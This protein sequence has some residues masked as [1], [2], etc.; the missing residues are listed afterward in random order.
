[1]TATSRLR[2]S[3][4]PRPE[5]GIVH[6]GPGAFFR[7]FCATY[8]AEAMKAEVGN[9]GIC[10]VSLRNTAVHD[11]LAPQDDAFTSVT[12]A[13]E[14]P[15][16]E[17]I[18]VI[19]QVLVAPENPGAVLEAMAAP[20]VKIVSMTIT[21]KGYCHNPSA[22]ALR[23]DDPD[24]VHDLRHP[25]APRTAIGFL[26]RA[27][28]QRR[29]AGRA[30]FTVLSCD[31][32]P[33]NGAL[34]RNVVCAFAKAVSPDLAQWIAA[35]VRFPSTMVD[36]ITPATTETDI[37]ALAD[38]TGYLDPA[39][40]MHEPFRQWVIE[41]DFVNGDRPAWDTV[42][43]QFVTDVAP[44]ESMKLRCLNGAHSALAYL[45]YLAGHETI[46]ETVADPHFAAYVD[47]LW[48]T[49]VVPSVPSPEGTDMLAYCASLKT[50]FLNPAIRHRT[51]QIAMDGSQ[52]V[53]QR[54]LVTIADCLDAG[55]P[56]PCLALA[57][58]GWIRYVQ[59]VDEKGAQIDVRDPLVTQLQAATAHA[60]PPEQV[61]AAILAER[62][63]F[64]PALAENITFVAAITTAYRALATHGAR[65]ATCQLLAQD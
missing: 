41:D 22:G 46:S 16:D 52:K 56:F 33:D 61:V 58:A 28:A 12:L 18:E 20:G 63:V 35:N 9:W 37:A 45:G 55:R 38:R 43:A 60:P 50:R 44:F 32:L 29:S 26:V 62:Q 21:E 42:G 25:E 23:M 27:L 7:A 36:R 47:R 51:W 17:I 65:E 19:D 54:L 49:E 10:G 64:D 4:V 40:V 34:A 31:N 48:H 57:V 3:N 6:L 59:G 53:P 5:V 13:P 30:P 39:C 1:M 11:Q 15:Q 2:R 14:G 8:T 24:I